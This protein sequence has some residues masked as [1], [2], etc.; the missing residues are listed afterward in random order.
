MA[1]RPPM[2]AKALPIKAPPSK[3]RI[4]SFSVAH[5]NK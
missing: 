3:L 5:Y 2:M 1:I 4:K